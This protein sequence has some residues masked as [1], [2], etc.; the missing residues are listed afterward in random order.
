MCSVAK[1][2]VLDG[3]G[4]ILSNFMR[5]FAIVRLRFVSFIFSF[6]GRDIVLFGI[7]R[8]VM[9]C[10]MCNREVSGKILRSIILQIDQVLVADWL[11]HV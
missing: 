4:G 7:S 11:C 1:A 3:K 2:F 9:R 5:G 8:D 6:W 10:D